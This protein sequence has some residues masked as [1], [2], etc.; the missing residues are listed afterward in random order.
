MNAFMTEAEQP[1]DGYTDENLTW[2]W[3]KDEYF[4]TRDDRRDY[5]DIAA[6]RHRNTA[7]SICFTKECARKEVIRGSIG[8]RRTVDCKTLSTSVVLT[9]SRRLLAIRW[10]SWPIGLFSPWWRWLKVARWAGG[11]GSL[12]DSL[13]SQ[14]WR[15]KTTTMKIET[16]LDWWRRA[17]IVHVLSRCCRL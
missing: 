9:G 14:S 17:K 1:H 2:S 7:T 10:P 5:S 12:R 3:V 4:R 16:G 6:S 13:A 8:R 11:T 15:I